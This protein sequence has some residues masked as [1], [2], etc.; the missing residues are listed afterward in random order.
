M[1]KPLKIAVASALLVCAIGLSPVAFAGGGHGHGHG[2]GHEFL[3]QADKNADGV[4]SVAEVQALQRERAQAIDADKDGVI[5]GV[6]IDA[7]RALMRAEHRNAR[8]AQLDANKDGRVSVDEFVAARS[9]H[10]ARM[11]KNADGVLD[12]NDR[13]HHDRGMH[14]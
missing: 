9:E 8:L 11:D 12:A 4:T 6:E 7:H 3:K 2:R 14:H 10:I 1:N 5:T 13:P